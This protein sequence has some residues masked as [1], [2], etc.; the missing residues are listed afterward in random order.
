M[1][2]TDVAASKQEREV[3]T[4]QRDTVVVR[5]SGDSGDGM[6]LA[7]AQMTNVSAALGNDVSTFP[8]YPA[9]IRAPA[10]TLAGVSGFQLCFSDHDIYTPG[11]E[12]DTL[13]AM[14][15]AALKVNLRD[16]KPGGTLIVNED[17]FEKNNLAK[18][19]YD[20]NPLE[21]PETL[22]PYRVYKVPMTRLTRDAVE[23]LGLSQREADRCKNFF[24]LGLIYWLYDRDPRPT[25][26]WVKEKFAKN[27]QIAEANLRA[28]RAGR[29][30]AQSTET[31]TVHYRVAPAR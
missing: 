31:F 23:G 29:N 27:P 17:A 13:V 4:E 19:H 15:P 18:A 28:L 25:E 12:V 16:L 5:F 30:Y 20:K 10:G 1:A 7:G 8:D 2:S 24:A 26:E 6:Q 9:E 11:D 21:D 14:N 22:A 3:Q